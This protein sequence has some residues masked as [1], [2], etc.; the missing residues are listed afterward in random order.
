MFA[1][2]NKWAG[3][4]KRLAAL[5]ARYTE[6]VV[7]PDLADEIERLEGSLID[8]VREAWASIDSS[9][10]CDNWAIE[11]LCEHLQAVTE[12]DIS[13]LLVN[14]PP[15]CS[16]TL[17]TSVCW[18]AWTWARRE[19]NYRSGP[20]VKF[21][22]GSYGHTLSILNSNLGRRLILSPWFQERWGKR[23]H[24]RVDQNT[25]S[26]WDNS[27]GGSRL[28]TSVG[29]S[30]L[31]LGGDIIVVDDPHNTESVESGAE[32]QSVLGWWK[33]L[34]TTRLNDPKRA[35][36]VVIMQRLHEEDVSGTILSSD[37]DWVHYC[38]PMEYDPRRH[39]T[40]SIGWND[41][42]GCNE[43]GEPLIDPAT[44]MPRDQEAA[45]E[46]YQQRAG[47]LMWPERF[48]PDE[49]EKIKTGLGPYM[50]SGRLQQAPAPQKGGIFQRDW[51]QVWEDQKSNM[52]PACEFVVASL[53]G[54]FTEKEEKRSVGNDRMGHFPVLHQLPQIYQ[55]LSR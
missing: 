29:G 22:C 14:F 36:I 40:T 1:A 10:F 50:A 23:F 26:Q 8:F 18:A 4:D 12:G 42:R 2:A 11:G 19:R 49:V 54:A 16:K 15:R 51:W 48:G 37:E 31:G 44:H 35:A 27:A 53:D 5:E 39:C 52:F 13:R 25:K 43:D 34:S 24:L 38:V 32:R 20:N 33:E 41:P 30:L 28:S 9:E 3:I 47:L 7:D 55:R 21:L 6:D 46:L 17:I 45:Q